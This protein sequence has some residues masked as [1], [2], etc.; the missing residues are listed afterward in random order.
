MYNKYI[1][2]SYRI[3]NDILKQ[4]NFTYNDFLKSDYWMKIKEKSRSSNAKYDYWR[5]CWVCESREN[6]NL[7]HTKYNNLLKIT[8][9]SIFP[10]CQSCH[11]KTH[12]LTK[13]NPKLSLKSAMKK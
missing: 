4:V 2:K 9:H 8:L 7:H 6:I 1:S 10:L 13:Q 11:Y 12:E 3:R 5:K